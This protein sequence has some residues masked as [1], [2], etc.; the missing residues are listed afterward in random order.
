M[1][2]AQLLLILCAFGGVIG[3]VA[4]A[5]FGLAGVAGRI[6][7]AGVAA[8]YGILVVIG[9]AGSRKLVSLPLTVTLPTLPVELEGLRIALD[10]RYAHWSAIVARAS[11]ARRR[12]R[13]RVES[14]SHRDRRRS[15]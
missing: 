11:R 10:L 1:W 5:P 6:A 13:A 14:R 8:V 3:A 7:I 12:G 9:Y 4:G 2:Y 15:H